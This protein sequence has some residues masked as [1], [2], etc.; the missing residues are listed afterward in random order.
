MSVQVTRSVQAILCVILDS[1]PDFFARGIKEAIYIRALQPSLNRDGGA[2]DFLH[3]MI[4]CSRSHV[5]YLSD[6][7]EAH[8]AHM[9]KSVGRSNTQ[10]YQRTNPLHYQ[11]PCT[12]SGL[13][14]CFGLAQL[15]V[16]Q[17]LRNGDGHHPYARY[18]STGDLLFLP[19]PWYE[20]STSHLSVAMNECLPLLRVTLRGRRL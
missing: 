8:S 11:H 19:S 6:V 15:C 2:T 10:H 14:P 20:L 3:P 12:T 9:R 18:E 13:A 7:T 1:E 5:C 4:H 16:A 17:G